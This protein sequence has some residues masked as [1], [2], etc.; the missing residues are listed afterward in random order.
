MNRNGTLARLARALIT[1]SPAHSRMYLN[2]HLLTRPDRCDPAMC[3]AGF[4]E[5]VFG[6]LLSQGD[7]ELFG[8]VQAACAHLLPI[9]PVFGRADLINSRRQ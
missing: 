5:A 8:L 7:W 2:P 3:F 6:A 9:T 4:S 1:A